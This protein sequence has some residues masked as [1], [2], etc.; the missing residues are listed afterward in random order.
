MTH[1]TSILMFSCCNILTDELESF[2]I[3][4]RI[5]TTPSHATTHEKTCNDLLF[6]SQRPWESWTLAPLHSPEQAQILIMNIT[7]IFCVWQSNYVSNVYKERFI[8]LHRRKGELCEGRSEWL[9]GWD[10]RAEEGFGEE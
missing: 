10:S 3:H 7:H 6:Q 1:S 2:K 8:S 5:S 4:S 9:E